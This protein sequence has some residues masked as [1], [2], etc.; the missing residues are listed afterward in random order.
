MYNPDRA[1]SLNFLLFVQI[2]VEIATKIGTHI[3]A[4]MTRT[5]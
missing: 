5:A 1:S 4:I 3:A 2:T